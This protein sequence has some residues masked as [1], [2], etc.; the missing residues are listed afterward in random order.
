MYKTDVAINRKKIEEAV[1]KFSKPELYTRDHLPKIL[2][3]LKSKAI[4]LSSFEILLFLL[5]LRKKHVAWRSEETNEFV[6][7]K[8]TELVAE[9]MTLQ[10]LTV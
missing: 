4:P 6:S 2:D 7:E 1:Q 9:V 8:V 10:G 3:H 5:A